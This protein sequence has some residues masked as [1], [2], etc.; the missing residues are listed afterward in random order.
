MRIAGARFSLCGASTMMR[1]DKPVTLS[2]Y[3]S[4]GKLVRTLVAETRGVGPHEVE[5]D[6]TDN[7]GNRVGSGVYF[8]RLDAPGFAETRKMLLLR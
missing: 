4:S 1:C 2:V 5:W 8:Y 3:D 6:G 7:T